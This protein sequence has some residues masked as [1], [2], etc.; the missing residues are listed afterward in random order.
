VKTLIIRFLAARYH[1]PE[2]RDDGS[3]AYVAKTDDVAMSLSTAEFF[4]RRGTSLSGTFVTIS[5][6][7]SDIENKIISEPWS[8]EIARNLLG[9]QAKDNGLF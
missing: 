4:E 1:T 7:A 5:Q 3:I 9:V 8:V 2:N 6:L